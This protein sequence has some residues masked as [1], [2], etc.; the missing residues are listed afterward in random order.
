[1]LYIKAQLQSGT[2]NNGKVGK[3]VTR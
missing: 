2:P 1:M 3:A